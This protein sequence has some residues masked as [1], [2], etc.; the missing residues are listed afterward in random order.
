MDVNGKLSKM[1]REAKLDF[2][3]HK[4]INLRADLN[5]SWLHL[6][7]NGSDKIGKNFDDFISKYYKWGQTENCV[8]T[9]DVPSAPA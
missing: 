9:S 4:N 1:Y 3:T 2:I 7:R 6:N 8:S 5:K